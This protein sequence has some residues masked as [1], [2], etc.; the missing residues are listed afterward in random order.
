MDKIKIILKTNETL[1]NAI[2]RNANRILVPAIDEVEIYKNDSALYDEVLAHR[3]GLIPIK[4]KRKLNSSEDCSCKGK[5]CN[6][7]QISISVKSKGP[8]IVYSKEIKG[9]V[10]IVHGEMPIVF[11]DNE[12]ELEFSGNVKAGRGEKHAK[13]SPGLAY[14]RKIAKIKLIK[15]EGREVFKKISEDL[16]KSVEKIKL[17]ETITSTEDIDKIEALDKNKSLEV[18]EGEEIVFFIESWGQIDAKEIFEEAVKELN[19][20]LKIVLDNLK[21]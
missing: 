3:V 20:N 2:R 10:D 17:N 8:G 18:Q 7:C 16:E 4:T 19:A 5:G 9:D 15:E 6:K 13:F 14:Y 11:L 12:Q 1:A 21:K